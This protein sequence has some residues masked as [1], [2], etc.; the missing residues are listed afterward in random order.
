MKGFIKHFKEVL[1]DK[2]VQVVIHLVMFLSLALLLMAG[3]E[4]TV[5]TSNIVNNTNQLNSDL[6]AKK[7]VSIDKKDNLTLDDGSTIQGKT[8]KEYVRT[9][10]KSGSYYLGKGRLSAEITLTDAINLGVRM[11]LFSL[12]VFIVLVLGFRV[13]RNK[14]LEKHMLMFYIIC[15]FPFMLQNFMYASMFT[16]YGTLNS[17]LVFIGLELILVIEG[18][19]VIVS[20]SKRDSRGLE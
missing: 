8:I 13:G 16:G 2:W 18:S 6:S 5:I 15:K 3:Y 12:M 7:V 4:F 10:P 1:S 19:L 17:M 14:K 11:Y 9:I 20:F